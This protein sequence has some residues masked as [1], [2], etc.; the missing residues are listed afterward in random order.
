MKF[1]TEVG[2][3]SLALALFITSAF[4]YTYQIGAPTSAVYWSSYPY[5]WYSFVLVGSSI[6]FFLEAKQELN[7][8]NF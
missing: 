5:Q 1:K 4:F 2:L 7:P 6:Y 8:R 3:V